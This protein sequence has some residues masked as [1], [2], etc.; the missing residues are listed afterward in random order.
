SLF[1]F[2]LPRE[3]VSQDKPTGQR[4][5]DEG[6]SER[7]A[8]MAKIRRPPPS[9]TCSG[10]ESRLTSF[11]FSITREPGQLTQASDADMSVAEKL[12]GATRGSTPQWHS[13]NGMKVKRTV[14]RLQ[15]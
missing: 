10:C 3:S 5:Q 9:G 14:R 15:A 4:A 13:I 8:V 12:T 1:C 11:A 7:F 2:A 6:T